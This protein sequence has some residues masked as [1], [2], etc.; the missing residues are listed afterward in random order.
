MFTVIV[1][2]DPDRRAR[3]ATVLREGRDGTIWVG[4]NKGL[5]RLTHSNGRSSMEHI[6]IGIPHAYP[7]QRMVG[8]VLE[9][10]HGSLW[11]AAPSGL[12]RRWPDGTSARYTAH[13]GLPHEYVHDLLEDHEGRLW[14]GTLLNGFF[15]FAADD[16]RHP[17]VVDL[18]FTYP[19]DLSTSWVFQLFETSDRRFWIATARG[20]VEFLRHGDEPGGRFRSYTTR[21]GLSYH[22]ITAVTE[23]AGGN[24]WLGTN[25]L[26]AMK[27]A[28]DGFTTFGG[29][30]GIVTVNAIFEDA[31]GSV[32]FRGSVLGDARTSV[33]EGGK[34]DLLSADR[35]SYYTRLG[36]FDGEGFV[37]FTPS[38]ATPAGLDANS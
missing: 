12:Y 2:A 6:E 5:Y 11:I 34:L 1:P 25:H 13:D 36:C 4:T 16:T 9:D 23:D 22:D 27:M 26:G 14:A 35:G 32:C 7:E 31:E 21:N 20:L 29:Q 28:R 33:F 3:A 8:D 17:P 18:R 24:L 38:A 10:A 19:R 37:W 30:D 15:R